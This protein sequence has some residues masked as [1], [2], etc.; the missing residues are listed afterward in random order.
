ML[1]EERLKIARVLGCL[2]QAEEA[3][4][5]YEAVEQSLPVFDEVTREKL[6]MQIRI[7]RGIVYGA[8]VG[9]LLQL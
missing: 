3:L 7:G 8:M 4:G 1:A 6:A 2:N 5:Q 9:F